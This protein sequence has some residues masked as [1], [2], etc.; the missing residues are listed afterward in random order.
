MKKVICNYIMSWS[1]HYIIISF[2]LMIQIVKKMGLLLWNFVLSPFLF[3]LC[4][5]LSNAKL[6]RRKIVTIGD[7]FSRQV[8]S[9]MSD[10]FIHMYLMSD[11]LAVCDVCETPHYEIRSQKDFACLFLGLFFL[12]FLAVTIRFVTNNQ[13]ICDVCWFSMAKCEPFLQWKVVTKEVFVYQKQF[14]CGWIV[15][16]GH[17]LFNQCKIIQN[18]KLSFMMINLSQKV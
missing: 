12:C 14:H 18:E 17:G 7:T 13:V 9:Q 6:L 1:G 15:S 16:T 10:L 5:L 3:F 2:Y 11:L 4:T 8:Q